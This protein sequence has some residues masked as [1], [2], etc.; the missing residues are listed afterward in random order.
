VR[1]TIRLFALSF[2]AMSLGALAGCPTDDA[3]YCAQDSDC[4]Q[5]V[6]SGVYT[7][8]D[9]GDGFVLAKDKIYCHPGK[10]YCYA[11]CKI[12]ADCQCVDADCSSDANKR[13]NKGELPGMRCN[14]QTHHCENPFDGGT[15]DLPMNLPL[16]ASCQVKA[17]CQSG[18]CADQ[19][20]CAEAC[21]GTCRSCA[22]AGSEGTCLQVPAGQDPRGDC[23]GDDPAC[24]GSCDQSGQCSYPAA[25]GSCGSPVCQDGALKTCN[26][27]GSCLPGAKGCNG[28]ACTPSGDA[29][30][31]SCTDKTAD[32][33]AGFECTGGTCQANLPLGAQCYGS[34]G[35]CASGFCTDGV[36]CNAASCEECFACNLNGSGTCAKRPAGPA[37]SGQCTGDAACGGG[38]CSEA[39]GCAY[40]PAGTACT[41]SCKLPDGATVTS[42]SVNHTCSVPK[43]TSCGAYTCNAGGTACLTSCADHAGCVA[44]SV[45]D[46]S[47]AGTAGAGVCIDPAKVLTLSGSDLQGAINNLGAKTHIKIPAGTYTQNLTI[48][49][50]SVALVGLPGAI[51]KPVPAGAAITVTNSAQVTVQGLTVT[52]ATG[53]GGHGIYCYGGASISSTLTV[54]ESVIESNSGIG[55]TATNCNVNL[56]R[57]TVRNNAGGGVKLDSGTF[58]LTDN[59]IGPDNGSTTSTLGGV[60]LSGGTVTFVNNTVVDNKAPPATSAGV[61]CSSGYTLRNS[62]LAGNSGPSQFLGC[63]FDHCAIFTPTPSPLPAGA[64]GDD[65]SLDASYKPAATSKC[66]NAGSNTGVSALDHDSTAR[67]KGGTVDLGAFEVK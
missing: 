64:I 35:A 29:C 26:S 28:F 67:I 58:K 55:I 45:C 25:G 63:A 61:I 41:Q 13:M 7:D 51:I 5:K 43:T 50:K 16:G 19:R 6:Q 47:A 17:Q 60:Q 46:R 8:S 66:I 1:P 12:D 62:I 20:C 48:T 53:A 32:C 11:G 18:Q 54:V 33:M 34:P 30:K 38:Q 23:K 49:G 4:P 14:Q 56:H 40:K 10:H 37:P 65:C 9:D 2:A 24:A 22:L 36:C 27:Q 44:G 42:C 15:G 57:S 59:L 3:R 52:G 31:T 21:E 39:G